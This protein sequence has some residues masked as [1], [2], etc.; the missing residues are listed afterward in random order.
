VLVPTFALNGYLEG[1]AEYAAGLCDEIGLYADPV[2]RYGR[3][4]AERFHAA[5]LVV[6]SG[7]NV[8]GWSCERAAA[9][10]REHAFMS[11]REIATEVR[12]Y[13]VDDPGQALGYHIGHRFLRERRRGRPPRD[14]HEEVLAAGPLPLGLLDRHLSGEI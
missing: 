7:L 8:F 5:R 13:A 2:D 14:F 12:R 4:V 9:Y 1:W 3:L 6:D 11:D 10:L